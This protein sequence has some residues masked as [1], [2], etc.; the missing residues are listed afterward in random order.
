MKTFRIFESSEKT[1]EQ[2][3]GI[4]SWIAQDVNIVK[5]WDI[6]QMKGDIHSYVL[7][8]SSFLCDIGEL[9]FRQNNTRY[10]IIK[11]VKYE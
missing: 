7:S 2:D 9:R 5:S 3:F 4:L 1:H 10:Q 11:I 8:T 6:S